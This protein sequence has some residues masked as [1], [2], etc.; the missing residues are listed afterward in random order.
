VRLRIHLADL[1]RAEGELLRAGD[2]VQSLLV[3]ALPAEQSEVYVDEVRV[4]GP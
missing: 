1:Q 3:Q 2:A 4:T